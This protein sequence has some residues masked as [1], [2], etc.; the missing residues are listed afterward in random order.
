MKAGTFATPDAVTRV[1]ELM[2]GAAYAAALRVAVRLG[3]PDVITDE[4][5][6]AAEIAQAAGT[7][8]EALRRLMRALAAC[9]VF[10]EDERGRYAHS[11]LS[12]VLREDAPL[13][14]RYNVLWSTEPWTWQAWPLL[15]QAIVTGGSVFA[16][17][18]GKPFFDYLH[19][20]ALESA[21]VFNRAMTQSSQLA[22]RA[23]AEELDL[24]GAATVADIAGGQGFLLATLLDKHH[25]IHGTLLDLPSVITQPDPRLAPGG[26]HA[27]RVMLIGGD[28]RQEIPVQADVY[29]LK[30][31]LE[32]DDES[33]VTTLRNVV[34]AAPATARVIVIENLVDGNSEMKFV[35]AMDLL[36]LLNVGG[37]KHTKEGLRVL[38]EKSGL[39]LR[40]LRA[41]TP[42]LHMY[43]CMLP[44]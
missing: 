2:L 10:T 36:L 1:R 38:I 20:D 43:E 15:E 42:H 6:T 5:L 12:R 34:A 4:P 29:I 16:D 32:W 18:F 14:A 24:T 31:I 25:G 13:G 22:A 23:I 35:T 27:G 40:G 26:V 7:D 33:T 21:E 17:T 30:N 3:L 37:K 44:A 39:R 11:A 28:C 9:G 8:G 41:V 19:S